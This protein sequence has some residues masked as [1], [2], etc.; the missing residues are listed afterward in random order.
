MYWAAIQ[1]SFGNTM[2][3]DLESEQYVQC[4]FEAYCTYWHFE[5][6]RLIDDA[7]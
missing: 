6:I 5:Y 3:L 2:L 1:T 7:E 4:S